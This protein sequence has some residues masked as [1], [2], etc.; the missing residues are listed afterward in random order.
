MS[1]PNYHEI[2]EVDGV[3]YDMR[4]LDA[5]KVALPGKGREVGSDLSVRV[6]FSCHVYTDRAEHGQAHHM[7]D[8]HGTR[9]AFSSDRYEM[10]LQLPNILKQRVR[11]NALAFEAKSAGGQ[12]NIIILETERG[13]TWT[14]VFCFSPSGEPSEVYMEVLSAYPKG[15][16]QRNLKRKQLS[17][18]ARQCLFGDVRVP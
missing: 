3:A 9:R 6:A 2:L 10:S 18:Y 4:H 1:V 12:K 7:T 8:H 13:R 15:I 14:V 5:F 17:Q 11:G 16:G